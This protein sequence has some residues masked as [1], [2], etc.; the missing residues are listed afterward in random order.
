MT[1]YEPLTNAIKVIDQHKGER[2]I[3]L[4]VKK[5]SGITDYFLIASAGN[6]LHAQSLARYVEDFLKKEYQLKPLHVEGI[7]EGRWIL[8]DYIDFIIHIFVEEER[9]FYS[10]EKLWGDAEHIDVETF[11]SSADMNHV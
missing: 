6:I 11:L 9:E 8:L 3:L 7:R 2:Q 5:I 10:L 4:D 1:T